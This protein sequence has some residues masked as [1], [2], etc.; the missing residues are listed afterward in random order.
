MNGGKGGESEWEREEKVQPT[1][2]EKE[3]KISERS[4]LLSFTETYKYTSC[5]YVCLK[6]RET[7]WETG[8]CPQGQY[9]LFVQLAWHW[10]HHHQATLT[11]SRERERQW[12]LNAKKVSNDGILF[13]S[14]TEVSFWIVERCEFFTAEGN[15][16]DHKLEK[17]M[18][19]MRNGQDA[20]ALNYCGELW[21]FRTWWW[22]QINMWT[23]TEAPFYMVC[24]FLCTFWHLGNFDRNHLML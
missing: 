15:K 12:Q 3:Q 7:A 20:D 18:R 14:N 17:Q 5:L 9:Q 16:E 13:S 2:K 11:H 24:L 10:C 8:Y 6:E 1:V 22:K 4:Q 23:L 19:L 21:T